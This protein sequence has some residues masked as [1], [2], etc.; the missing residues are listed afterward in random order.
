MGPEANFVEQKSSCLARVLG[1]TKILNVR[2]MNLVTLCCA[3][4]VWLRCSTN[5]TQIIK[6]ISYQWPVL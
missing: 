1:V 4:Q 3:T 2:D 5:P 6:E